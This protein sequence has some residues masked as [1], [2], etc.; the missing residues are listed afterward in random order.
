MKIFP[1]LLLLLGMCNTVV[2]AIDPN[3]VESEKQS[4]VIPATAEPVSTK[5]ESES[6]PEN[7]RLLSP[8]VKSEKLKIQSRNSLTESSELN[9]NGSGNVWQLFSGLFVVLASI[10]A[11]V[12]LIKRFG[13]FSYTSQQTVKV[14]GGISLGTREKVVL[15]EVGKEQLLIGVAPGRV[16]I[17]HQLQEPIEVNDS[18][19]SFQSVFGQR[20]KDLFKREEKK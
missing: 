18:N 15:I 13:R 1:C 2:A 7:H 11:L 6:L 3:R 9:S 5:K 12:W 17:L 16:N 14:L 4:K 19:E 10:V 20:V 8:N